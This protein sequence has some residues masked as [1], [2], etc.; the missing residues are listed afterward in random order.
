M[1]RLV[2]NNNNNYYCTITI[3]SWVPD[4]EVQA[5]GFIDVSYGPINNM[6]Q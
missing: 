3:A 4:C 1:I 2:E 5:L 6:L